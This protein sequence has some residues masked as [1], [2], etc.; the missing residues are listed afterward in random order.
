[1]YSCA[2]FA[3]LSLYYTAGRCP[4]ATIAPSMCCVYWQ[5]L[6]LGRSRRLHWQGHM[7]AEEGGVHVSLLLLLER[8]GVPE[9]RHRN[10]HWQIRRGRRV[11][12]TMVSLPV[13]SGALPLLFKWVVSS[14]VELAFSSPCCLGATAV[15]LKL[16]SVV[17]VI[18]HSRL[19][20]C[21]SAACGCSGASTPT[22][23]L[24]WG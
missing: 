10:S 24:N 22:G 8:P 6:P 12:I 3:K 5:H 7:E 14:I 13:D 21:A 4:G 18:R 17:I 11:G 2:P 19:L 15:L 16:V 23:F 9:P 20:V 1:V